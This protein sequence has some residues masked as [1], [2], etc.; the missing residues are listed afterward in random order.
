MEH[1]MSAEEKFHGSFFSLDEQ[2]IY[3]LD[4]LDNG[5]INSVIANL[6]RLC[7]AVKLYDDLSVEMIFIAKPNKLKGDIITLHIDDSDY[8]LL[9]FRFCSV[10]AEENEEVD[11]IDAFNTFQSK[12]RSGLEKYGYFTMSSLELE[13]L[14]GQDTVGML[15]GKKGSKVLEFIDKTAFYR[16]FFHNNVDAPRSKNKNYV[17]LMVNEDTSLIKIGYSNDPSYREGT[18]H[19]K[20]PVINMIAC[21][22]AP[23]ERER[24]LHKMFSRKRRRGEWFK[25]TIQDLKELGQFM[26]R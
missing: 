5:P 18:L 20:E 24:A 11:A 3:R 13:Q 15:V 8:F 2:D 22:D 17:Y 25:L 10:L 14:K 16:D 9:L 1:L 4:E 7:Y 21:W 19:S 26:D 12:L 23:K 6:A